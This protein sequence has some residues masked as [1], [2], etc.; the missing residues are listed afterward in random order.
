MKNR[1]L[2]CKN[3]ANCHQR[4]GKHDVS[5]KG[6]GCKINWPADGQ[7]IKC[8]G[9]AATCAHEGTPGRVQH[10]FD[11]RALLKALDLKISLPTRKPVHQLQ[12]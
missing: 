1:A 5:C 11:I 2:V 8:E 7:D 3:G 9:E 10:T 6:G 12:F 4:P